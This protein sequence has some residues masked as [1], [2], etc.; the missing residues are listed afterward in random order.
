MGI[1][2]NPTPNPSTEGNQLDVSQPGNS[3]FSNFSC[4]KTLYK[5]RNAELGAPPNS[6]CINISGSNPLLSTENRGT[7]S[8]TTGVGDVSQRPPP[9]TL[10]RVR[11]S[12]IPTSDTRPCQKGKEREKSLPAA[13]DSPD[14]SSRGAS[15]RSQTSP[16]M[17]CPSRKISQSPP[18]S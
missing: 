5:Q 1:N 3:R 15:G 16:Q 11:L 7:P 9:V 2:Q 12:R 6:C 10:Q 4:E 17:L 8:P 13:D 18:G 14:G